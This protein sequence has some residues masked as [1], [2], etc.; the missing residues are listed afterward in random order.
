MCPRA[1]FCWPD[2]V[3]DPQVVGGLAERLEELCR[4]ADAGTLSRLGC[5]VEEHPG[6]LVNADAID[7]EYRGP[8][9]V[10]LARHLG[11]EITPARLAAGFQGRRAR[12]ASDQVVVALPGTVR[13]A[14]EGVADTRQQRVRHRV[15]QAS[16]MLA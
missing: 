12:S 10:R 7:P 3:Y 11:G 6:Q 8:V 4:L 14:P 5:P 1:T 16:R 2:S 15:T 13:S 9:P